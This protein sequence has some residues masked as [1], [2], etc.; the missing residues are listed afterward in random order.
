MPPRREPGLPA[1]TGPERVG[2]MSEPVIKGHCL[3][4]TITYSSDAD[5]AAVVICHCDE[6]QRQSG[7]PFSLNVIVDRER[8]TIAGD[9]LTSFETVGTDSGEKRQRMFCSRCGSTV[10]SILAEAE[11]LAIIKAGTLEDRSWLEPEMEVWC[12]SAHPW[13]QSTEERGLFPRG[14]PT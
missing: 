12:E 9:T 4:G 13:L 10:L 6:C 5:P 7:A 11:D 3:C 1:A 2:V 8:F 14:L